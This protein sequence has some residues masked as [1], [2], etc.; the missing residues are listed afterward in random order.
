MRGYVTISGS[1]SSI[2]YSTQHFTSP[3][4]TLHLTFHTDSLNMLGLDKEEKEFLAGFAL[5]KIDALLKSFPRL[6]TAC[7]LDVSGLSPITTNLNEAI[8]NAFKEKRCKKA[9]NVEDKPTPSDQ[10]VKNATSR[11]EQ[12]EQEHEKADEKSM[13]SKSEKKKEAESSKKDLIDVL[14]LY[15]AS[16][17]QKP[18]VLLKGNN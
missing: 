11:L 9:F 15:L 2:P 7:V 4:I 6:R 10:D 8:T 5:Y 16:G 12:A 3:E 1:E 13:K 18:I 17:Q 14:T